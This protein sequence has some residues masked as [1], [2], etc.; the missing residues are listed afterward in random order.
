MSQQIVIHPVPRENVPYSLELEVDGG[1][2]VNARCGATAFWGPDAVLA[3][4][5][6]FDALQI[7]QRT[8]VNAGIS[9]AIAAATG[10][11]G[12]LQITPPTN[13]RLLRNI[14][15]GLEFIHAHITHFYQQSLP[16][17]LNIA[18]PVAGEKLSP[19]AGKV[20]REHYWHS[21]EVLAGI[22]ST[23][24][25][26]GGRIPYTMSIV[27]GGV[28]VGPDY[29]RIFELQSRWKAARR[30]VR[31]VFISDVETL[32]TSYREYGGMGVGAQRLLA[33]GA[34]PQGGGRQMFFPAGISPGSAAVPDTSKITQDVA[35][36]WFKGDSG[37]PGAMPEPEI[38]SQA[39]SWIPV[40][41]YEEQRY[42]TGPLA[43]MILAGEEKT[44]RLGAQAYSAM[45][46]HLARAYE[47]LLLAE[48]MEEWISELKP[49]KP[50][51]AGKYSVPEEGE[52]WSVAESPAGSV[53][54]RFRI[55]EERIEFYRVF[56][57]ASWNLSPKDSSG[58]A[59][60]LERALVGTPVVNLQDPAE[61]LRVFRAFS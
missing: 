54:H 48:K 7:V 30:F 16:D 60:P 22:H 37:V 31:D 41:K 39:Y 52:G 45:G 51:I 28:A 44:A 32:F 5:H 15:Q 26:F 29:Q 57:A 50:A 23:I 20:L 9:H 1:R 47:S 13:G 53:V 34:F 58:G 10:L 59:G 4:K 61:V 56:G 42:E 46:R 12:L 25:A 21:F 8:H 11:E 40:L 14:L 24:A 27:P 49:Q 43:R 17:F 6:P 55:R 2:V 33:M 35:Y 38:K 36:A 3:G 18:S 19:A